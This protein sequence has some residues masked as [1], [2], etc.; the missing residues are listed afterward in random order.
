MFFGVSS[1]ERYYRNL[2]II[3]I[4]IS[5][6]ILFTNVIIKKE[7]AI[8][9]SHETYRIKTMRG[10]IDSLLK[11][12][13]IILSETDKVIP[14]LDTKLKDG[15]EIQIVRSFPV[16]IIMGSD[17]IEHY[18]TLIKVDEIL[19]EVGIELGA[20]DKVYPDLESTLKG[21]RKIELVKVEKRI[22]EENNPVGYEVSV[23]RTDNYYSGSGEINRAGGYGQTSE[24]V[25]I[26]Y[27]NGKEVS[28]Q[29][30][31][32]QYLKEPAKE[33]LSKGKEKFVVMEDGTPYRYS[34][35]IEM[36]ASAYDLSYASCGKYPSHPQYGI[37][38]SGTKAR[39]GV[40]AVDPGTIKLNSKL[41]VESLDRTS[42]YGF[43]SAED[44]GS[45]I[46]SNRIDLFISNNSQALR[47]GIRK[48]RVYVLEDEFDPILMVGYSR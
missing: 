3:G 48:V 16:K 46:Q 47:Y 44:T 4:I 42:D 1:M 40:V 34:K 13:G 7:V 18:T 39:P 15:M 29:L 10:D 38:F 19:S 11:A 6:G 26:I 12:N 35:V 22:I 30:K 27:E 17:V 43:S 37:T 28:R 5:L 32:W 9:D 24:S 33:L 45:A 14:G 41:Y 20:L 36:V 2:V 25:E 23:K 21:D 31:E 8:L